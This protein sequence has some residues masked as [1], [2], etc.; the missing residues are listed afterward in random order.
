[1]R[2]WHSALVLAL[3]VLAMHH[4]LVSGGLLGEAG[5][6]VFRAVWGFDHQAR[7]L[8][9]PFWT[10]RVG[11]P[12]GVKL[13]ILPF[14]ST[15]L[16][17]PL[18]LIFGPWVGYNLWMLALVVAGGVTTAWWVGEAS[19]SPSAGLLAGVAMVTQPS[20]LLALTDGTPEHVAFWSLPALFAALWQTSRSPLRRWPLVAGIFA[21]VVALD[22]PYH[23]VFSVPLVLGLLWRCTWRG[24]GRFVA[25]AAA[26]VVLVGLLYYKLPLAGPVDNRW[27][28]A[29]KLSVWAQW[30]LRRVATAWDY[31]YT[32]AFIPVLSML[33]AVGLA[34]LRPSRSWPWLLAAAGFL[35]L[36][37]G[38]NQENAVVLGDWIPGVGESVGD[39]VVA[40]NDA[41]APSSIRFPRRWLVPAALALWTAAGLGL[42]RLPAEWMRLFVAV[43]VA[44]GLV[45]LTLDRTGYHEAFPKLEVPAPAFATFVHDHELD[46]AALVL[47]TVR[48][49]SRKHERFELPIFAELDDSIRSADG[50]FLQVALGRPLVN[51]PQGLFTLVARSR[52]ADEVARLVQDLNDLCTPQTMGTAIAPSALQE[53]ARRAAAAR[54]LVERGLR[55]VV[56]DEALYG[57][58]GLKWARLPFAGHLAEERRFDDGSGVSVFVLQP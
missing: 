52:Q 25:T 24:R 15:L 37:L 17:A 50:P 45:W 51:A 33:A 7:G 10:E 27:D 41:L 35:G 8:P 32:P 34:V 6:D 55:F 30:D 42:S 36:A 23:A 31:T 16:G 56:L 12:A 21:T 4:P 53:P 46:G 2:L 39:A 19:R 9:L 28:N 11:F 26:G 22:S 13:V 18:H 14:V 54:Y 44:S 57:S 5:T 58:E 48:G 38:G 1:M 29:A 3:L 47:P 43:P 20:L 40:V 49:A